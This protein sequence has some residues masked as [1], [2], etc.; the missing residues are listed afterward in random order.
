MTGLRRKRQTKTTPKAP[1]YEGTR[2][3][4]KGNRARY[5][6]KKE[7][8]FCVHMSLTNILYFQS[9][10]TDN[11]I[12]FDKPHSLNMLECSPCV[13]MDIKNMDLSLPEM[14]ASDSLFMLQIGFLSFS[15]FSLSFSTDINASLHCFVDLE[16]PEPVVAAS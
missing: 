11:I 14:I 9:D 4:K 15:S 13:G 6:T 2:L 7:R 12:I 3:Q 8:E 1:F 16:D 10:T 5:P